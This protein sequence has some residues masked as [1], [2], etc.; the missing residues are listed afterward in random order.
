MIK[1]VGAYGLALII[2]LI[3]GPASA[4]YMAGLW[5]GT[6]PL[7][8][9]DIEIDGWRSDFAIGSEA[10]DP[11][12]RARV[13]RHGLLGLAK[14]EAVYFTRTTDS[15][16]EPLRE[17]CDYRI[18]GGPMPADWWSITLYNG[19]SFLPDNTDA[20]LSVD[21][22]Q[23]DVDDG[24]WKAIASPNR[25]VDGTAWISSK[26]AKTFDLTLRLYVPSDALLDAPKDTLTPPRVERMS[27][28]GEA[29]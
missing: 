3:A 24:P 6:N 8:F 1:R 15:D 4:L 18:T 28:E 27:C 17:A 10:A 20:A 5:P 13:A 12:T 19:E 21:A 26:A 9:G 25:P 14:S 2:G 23:V 16:G 7:N 22:T 29:A 11:Y